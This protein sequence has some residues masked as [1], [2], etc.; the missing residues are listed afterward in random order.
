MKKD[1]ARPVGRGGVS[2]P[3]P[4]THLSSNLHAVTNQKLENRK[5][6]RN[7]LYLLSF[8]VSLRLHPQAQLIKSWAPGG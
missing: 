7:S 5:R 4:S 8:G 6:T 1:G 2:T 3:F